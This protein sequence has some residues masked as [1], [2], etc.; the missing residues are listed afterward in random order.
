MEVP[1]QL[2]PHV[3]TRSHLKGT[4]SG[5][6]VW[7]WSPPAPTSGWKA[8]QASGRRRSFRERILSH[9]TVALCAE[10]PVKVNTPADGADTGDSGGRALEELTSGGTSCLGSGFRGQKQHRG[11]GEGGGQ[12][13][14]LL[15]EGWCWWQKGGWPLP[16]KIWAPQ[17]HVL[18]TT[19][20]SPV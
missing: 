7:G 4:S 10:F 12:V 1:S 18:P 16:L 6:R 5:L 3:Q 13:A 9:L 2:H 17:C 19:P 15:G 8:W 20:P 14:M 11:P